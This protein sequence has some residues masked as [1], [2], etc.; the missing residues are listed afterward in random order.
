MKNQKIIFL[1]KAILW[2]GNVVKEIIDLNKKFMNNE[3]L[4]HYREKLKDETGCE[5]Y[6][7][8]KEYP[9]KPDET[10]PIN[11]VYSGKLPESLKEYVMNYNNK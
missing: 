5:A 4:E 9:I 10:K 1:S 8:L 11:W 3:E 2:D 6:F 7:E